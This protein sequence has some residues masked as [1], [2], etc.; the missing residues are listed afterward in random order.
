MSVTS[1]P[2]ALERWLRREAYG[3]VK[4]DVR[5]LRDLQEVRSRGA[6]HRKGSTYE[7]SLDRVFGPK[8][9]AAAGEMLLEECLKLVERLMAFAMR[10]PVE[11]T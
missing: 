6:A 9:R 11:A 2:F 3:D 8:R 4:R 1:T 10:K 5:L 7:K